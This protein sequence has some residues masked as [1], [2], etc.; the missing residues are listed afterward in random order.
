MRIA[1]TKILPPLRS[2]LSELWS[3]LGC[4]RVVICGPYHRRDSSEQTS[5]GNDLAFY[6]HGPHVMF[7]RLIC[8]AAIAICCCLAPT[9]CRAAE[10]R[11]NV[12]LIISD[13]QGWTDYGFMGHDEISTPHLDRLAREGFVFERAYCM[14]SYSGA[15]CCP[16]RAMLLSTAPE[17]AH[18]NKQENHC[19]FAD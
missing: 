3:E 7:T 1:R 14:R 6:M 8:L 5:T 2:Y 16:S 19:G 18:G 15:V 10:A 11:P 17:I 9:S 4:I 13:D 12:V